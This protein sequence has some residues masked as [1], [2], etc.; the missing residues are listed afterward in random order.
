MNNNRTIFNLAT[1][2]AVSIVAPFAVFCT[3]N[4][5]T[6]FAK[7]I[8]VCAATTIFLAVVEF[9]ICSFSSYIEKY[10]SLITLGFGFFANLITGAIVIFTYVT[11]LWQAIIAS[12]ILAVLH[13]FLYPITTAL[14]SIW[15]IKKRKIDD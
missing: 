13:V 14:G 12:G 5:P 6:S 10:S 4:E 9:L 1:S 15:Y 7:A 2:I 11:P 8:G 3:V